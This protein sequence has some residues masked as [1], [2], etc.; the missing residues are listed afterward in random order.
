MSSQDLVVVGDSWWLRIDGGPLESAKRI[1]K[2]T[3]LHL[4]MPFDRFKNLRDV[5]EKGDL[6]LQFSDG[7]SMK[8]IQQQ[9]ELASVQLRLYL[10]QD[11]SCDGPVAVEGNGSKRR[12]AD[13]DP[14]SSSPETSIPVSHE[15]SGLKCM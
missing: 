11:A 13:P 9:I 2:I 8:V 14:S 10:D 1:R 3:Y 4:I 12:R 5:L 7:R 6:R 15:Q